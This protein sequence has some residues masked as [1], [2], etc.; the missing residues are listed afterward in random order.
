MKRRKQRKKSRKK[1]APGKVAQFMSKMML[2]QSGKWPLLECIITKGWGEE[3]EI[4][5]LCVARQSPRGDVVTGAC[6]VD[7]GCLGVKNAFAAHFHSAAEYRRE[8]RSQFTQHQE[9]ISCDLDLAAK[10]IDEAVKYANSLGFR[11]NRDLKDVLLVMGE[12][13]PENCAAEI[14]LGG[15]DGQP[16]FIAG[17]YD[18]PDR[19]MRILDRK[20]GRENYNFLAPLGPPGF[21]D[22]DFG[23]IED[24]EEDDE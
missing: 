1:R 15:E 9:M 20:V 6:V 5:Q 11:P 19:I 2:R 17:P 18:D 8:L 24:W 10:V 14:P 22:D 16:L 4:I 12:T 7:L 23:E 21:F 3:G 13:H